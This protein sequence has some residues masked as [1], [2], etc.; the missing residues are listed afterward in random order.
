MF[1]KRRVGWRRF[2]RTR[3]WTK[4]RRRRRRRG[5]PQPSASTKLKANPPCFVF[6][7]LSSTILATTFVSRPLHG[8]TLTWNSCVHTGVAYLVKHYRLQLEQVLPPSGC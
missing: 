6:D 2:R 8:S 5:R 4:R 1:W 7:D 3:R